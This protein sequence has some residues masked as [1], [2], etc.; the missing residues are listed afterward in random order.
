MFLTDVT[1]TSGFFQFTH[2]SDK[3]PLFPTAETDSPPHS[4]SSQRTNGESEEQ[5]KQHSFEYVSAAE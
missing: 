3:L 4:A 1:C 2:C 5:K